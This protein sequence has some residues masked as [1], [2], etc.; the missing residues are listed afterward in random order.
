MLKRK[1]KVQSEAGVPA[2]VGRKGPNWLRISVCVNIGLVV[3]AVLVA[4]GMYVLHLSDTEP[5]FCA[6]CHVM[7]A[8]VTSY[9]TSTNLDHVH[10]QAGVECKECHDYP[11]SAE[12]A[13]GWA[14]ITG[15]YIVTG[16]P[17]NPL[18]R[19]KF[20]DEMC[21]QCHISNE[22]LAQ[23]TALLDR[24][25]HDSHWGPLPC[26]TCHI[27]H[28]EQIDYCSTCHDNGGQRMTG[29]DTVLRTDES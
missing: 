10:E 12:I 22:Y 24:N 25:P 7:N 6:T 23:K 9:L 11:L 13:S 15:N 20:D 3:A 1:P 21:L 16:D 2:Q 8:H 17:A 28:G 19:R 14:F 5:R 18:P 27:S 29:P 26:N 4:G